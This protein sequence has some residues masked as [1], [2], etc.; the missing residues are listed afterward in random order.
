VS[1]EPAAAAPLTNGRPTLA[2]VSEAAAIGPTR[3]ASA[4]AEPDDIFAVTIR[5]M[6]LPASALVRRYV[7]CVAPAIRAQPLPSA[8]QRSQLYAYVMVP[9]PVQVPSTAVSFAPTRAVPARD[10]RACSTGAAAHA[11]DEGAASATMLA[12]MRSAGRTTRLKQDGLSA[13]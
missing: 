3:P 13:G 4:D 6:V 12:Q 7:A 9:A 5:P 10:G 2:S 1:V 11:A 8:S